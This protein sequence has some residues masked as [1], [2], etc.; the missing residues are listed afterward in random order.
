MGAGAGLYVG[1]LADALYTVGTGDLGKLDPLNPRFGG[2]NSYTPGH[3]SANFRNKTVFVSNQS[4]WTAGKVFVNGKAYSLTGIGITGYFSL[5]GLNG[6]FLKA[7]QRYFV[8]AETTGG[9][10][11]WPD[12]TL[13]KGNLYIWSGINWVKD[14]VGLDEGAVN[15]VINQALAD[16]LRPF[17]DK[18]QNT[19]RNTVFNF[20]VGTTADRD[21]IST[22]DA[23]TFYITPIAAE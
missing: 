3:G 15:A 6:T 17:A 21:A 22:K 10:P 19:T 13:E 14:A 9:V 12:V 23:N 11:I 2:L 16:R 5:D 20:W 18:T 8:N 4:G 7:G 1:Y